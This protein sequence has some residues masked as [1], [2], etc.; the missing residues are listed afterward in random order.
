MFLWLGQCRG[1][2]ARGVGAGREVGKGDGVWVK[3]AGHEDGDGRYHPWLLFWH[4]RAPICIYMDRSY[5]TLDL[6]R[7]I[8]V[9]QTQEGILERNMD[10][11]GFDWMAKCSQPPSWLF[12]TL[13]NARAA[14]RADPGGKG[15]E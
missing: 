2:W 11:N 7:Y 14:G 4:L 12:P 8:C 15:R 9:A 1:W 6:N 3:E 13:V 10:V 5:L